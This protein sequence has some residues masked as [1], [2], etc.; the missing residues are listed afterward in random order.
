MI[1]ITVALALLSTFASCDA[2]VSLKIPSLS[3]TTSKRPISGGLVALSIEQDRWTDWVGTSEP[4]AYFNKVLSNLVDVNHVPFYLRIGANS[5]DRT[6]FSTSTPYSYAEFPPPTPAVPFPEA[7]HLLVGQGF[8]DSVR[9]LPNN[10]HVVWGLNFK[11]SSLPEAIT[12]TRSILTAFTS[13]EIRDKNIQL[14]CLELGNEANFWG[15]LYASP[16]VISLI[17]PRWN[18]WTSE[19][20]KEVVFPPGLG[21]WAGSLAESQHTS[22]SWSPAA[23]IADGIQRSFGGKYLKVMSQHHYSGSAC[24]GSKQILS[25][26]ANKNAIRSNVSIFL[27]DIQGYRYNGLDFVFGETNSYACHG[28]A[29]TS[30][31]GSAALWALDYSLFSAT[32]GVSQVY[33][34]EG[35]GFKYNLI[36]PIE[37]DRSISDG[38]PLLSPL[39]PHV[40]PPYYAAVVTR[41]A[42]GAQS[43]IKE[44]QT[45]D[46]YLSAYAFFDPLPPRP[47]LGKTHPPQT[48]LTAALQDCKC[49]DR[50]VFINLELFLR[51]EDDGI[52]PVKQLKLDFSYLDGGLAPSGQDCPKPATLEVKRLFI[53]FVPFRSSRSVTEPLNEQFSYF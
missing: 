35:I 4:N 43:I 8:Y 45:G 12:Q 53:P 44:I 1:A 47:H 22:T 24:S 26:L 31:V 11:S 14:D 48:S 7:N 13:Q 5:Q 42:L 36:Q 21:F 39:P 10:T 16:S 3:Q 25:D 49:A 32:L 52:R 27:P 20:V 41:D 51:K 37:L 18:E 50:A 34:H 9:H 28:A 38:R 15:S 30:N 33:F 40:Q 29:D 46:D 23:L 2:L 17:S 6:F 19:I